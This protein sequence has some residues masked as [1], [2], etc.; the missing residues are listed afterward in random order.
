MRLHHRVSEVR[1]PCFITSLKICL[2]VSLV[3]SSNKCF[4]VFRPDSIFVICFT[5]SSWVCLV[6]SVTLHQWIS[7]ISSL[8]PSSLSSSSLSVLASGFILSCNSSPDLS[9]AFTMM[10]HSPKTFAMPHFDVIVLPS[11][12]LIFGMSVLLYADSLNGMFLF[13]WTL[14]ESAVSFFLP[15]WSFFSNANS[16]C[17]PGQSISKVIIWCRSFQGSCRSCPFCTS[18]CSGDLHHSWFSVAAYGHLCRSQQV[19]PLLPGFSTARGSTTSS[20]NGERKDHSS[21]LPDSNW[22]GISSSD[23]D[24]QCTHTDI[25][26]RAMDAHDVDVRHSCQLHLS[27]LIPERLVGHSHSAFEGVWGFGTSLTHSP[28]FISSLSLSMSSRGPSSWASSTPPRSN[29]ASLHTRSRPSH[30]SYGL[31]FTCYA[32][33]WTQTCWWTRLPSGCVFSDPEI[34]DEL[35]PAFRR[36]ITSH[37]GLTVL[38]SLLSSCAR[39]PCCDLHGRC[40]ERTVHVRHMSVWTLNFLSTGSTKPTACFRPVSCEVSHDCR[41]LLVRRFSCAWVHHNCETLP[42][43]VFC[44]PPSHSQDVAACTIEFTFPLD[45]AHVTSHDS[46]SVSPFVNSLGGMIWRCR[47]QSFWVSLASAVVAKQMP[48]SSSSDSSRYPAR[49][50][51]L[52]SRFLWI[53]RLFAASLSDFWLMLVDLLWVCHVMSCHVRSKSVEKFLTLKVHRCQVRLL[54]KSWREDGFGDGWRSVAKLTLIFFFY[55]NSCW[56]R[57]QPSGKFPRTHCCAKC[58]RRDCHICQLLMRFVSIRQRSNSGRFLGLWPGLRWPFC[59]CHVA[60]S[61]THFTRAC[62][63]LD[64]TLKC[65]SVCPPSAPFTSMSLDLEVAKI[66]DEFSVP[67]AF[68]TKLVDSACL[69]VWQFAEYVDDVKDWT[70]ILSSLEPPIVDR[71]HIASVRRA[72][73]AACARDAELV[74]RGRDHPGEDMDAPIESNRG[75]TLIEEHR[76]PMERKKNASWKITIERENLWKEDCTKCKKLDIPKIVM[77]RISSTLRWMTTTLIS[78]SQAC[79][80]RWWNHHMASTFTTW[81]RRSRI[82]LNEKHFKVIF[83][84]IEHSIPSAKSQKMRLKLLGTL[85]YAR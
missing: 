48:V 41:R 51:H 50:L 30:G 80:T 2:T 76:N 31:S 3:A 54:L 65:F 37:L 58:V 19:H 35:S 39:F 36:R 78:T 7:S 43:A 61:C 4:D 45:P 16:H 25:D 74:S 12:F 29:S 1:L 33:S 75:R 5:L 77:T 8:P 67:E 20:L 55:G 42:L 15:F 21:I 22:C 79:R 70:G 64:Q 63:Q 38:V 28:S 40:N 14:Q 57:S 53:S 13:F 23:T 27:A 24:D 34:H 6:L 18:C 81:F 71:M 84:N 44:G 10:Q 17:S 11:S 85:N 9:S 68:R 46:S 62:F 47:E 73:E 72:Y 82:N 59:V 83:N 69:K 60:P 56:S 66:L 52:A 49:C 26:H 32:H